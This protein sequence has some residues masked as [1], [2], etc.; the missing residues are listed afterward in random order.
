MIYP[1]SDFDQLKIDTSI[2]AMRSRCR[3]LNIINSLGKVDLHKSKSSFTGSMHTKKNIKSHNNIKKN[4][5]EKSA[6]G[7]ALSRDF[8]L[9]S[10]LRSRIT[11]NHLTIDQINN[12]SIEINDQMRK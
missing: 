7:G 3:L 12:N 1:K 2:R 4:L 9:A 6:L 8:K 11:L 10:P 5:K